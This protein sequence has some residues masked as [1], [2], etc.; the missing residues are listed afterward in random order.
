LSGLSSIK[1]RT[2]FSDKR[3]T[4]DAD[5]VRLGDSQYTIRDIQNWY[6]PPQ[7]EADYRPFVHFYNLF[8]IHLPTTGH[9]AVNLAIALAS[10]K[11]TEDR[12]INLGITADVGQGKNA[13]MEQFATMP[14]VN[15][16]TRTS[17]SDY[18]KS[19]MGHFL[20]KL[21]KG[22]I[23]EGVTVANSVKFSREFDNK[24]TPDKMSNTYDFI[25]EGEGLFTS[26]NVDGFLTFYD[27][28]IE[29]GWYF[30]G[31][32]YNGQYMMG[33]TWDPERL[34]M[35]PN[36]PIRHGTVIAAPPK[37]FEIH[38][39]SRAGWRTR[40]V[41]LNYNC[42]PE[43]NDY[44]RE[45][46]RID[47]IKGR[48]MFQDQVR[49]ALEHITQ[50]RNVTVEI[51]DPKVY[52]IMRVAEDFVMAMRAEPTGLRA[53]K[54]VKKFFKSFTLFNN[55]HKVTELDAVICMSLLTGALKIPVG[56]TL[57]TSGQDVYIRCGTRL[58]F[59]Y[60]LLAQ[61]LGS[62]QAIETHLANTFKSL[63]GQTPLYRHERLEEIRNEL[64]HGAW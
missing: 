59:Q 44:T 20:R 63:D 34:R 56:K 14:Q 18:F 13:T 4:L 38:L 52:K 45:A 42:L 26:P 17:I 49:A 36:N 25:A 10:M 27:Q 40:L 2:D 33:G 60:S 62:P 30:G 29:E 6:L 47:R 37:D 23:P 64:Y 48:P 11:L 39:L 8:E 58:H 57:G 12:Q 50:A 32:D 5:T 16:F 53:A 7:L 21:G 43:E 41:C 24:D 28:A 1:I 51:E 55:R 54:D 46:I 22:Y 35:V 3:S 9:F 15:F 31:D 61:I 19:N